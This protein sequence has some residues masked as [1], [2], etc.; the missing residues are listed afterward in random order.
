MPDLRIKQPDS[1][2]ELDDWRY[3]HNEI[4]PTHLLSLDEVRERAQ[5]HHLEV[6]YCG[7][8]LVG[9]STIIEGKASARSCIRA[10]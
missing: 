10:G 5:H 9:C 7:D 6:A 3:V 1:D 2:A 8:A 4:I